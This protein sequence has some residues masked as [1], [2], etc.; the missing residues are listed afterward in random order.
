MIRV[1]LTLEL[2]LIKS[3]DLAF[4]WLFTGTLNKRLREMSVQVKAAISRLKSQNT[5][6]REIAKCLQG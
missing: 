4:W 3:A 1:L 2:E 6:F 5:P